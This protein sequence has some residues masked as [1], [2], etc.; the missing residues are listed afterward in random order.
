M[1]DR[2]FAKLTLISLFIVG[3]NYVIRMRYCEL[4][5][6]KAVIIRIHLRTFGKIIINTN[7]ELSICSGSEL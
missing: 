4:Y 3:N 1:N 2:Q 5:R 6:L 7:G